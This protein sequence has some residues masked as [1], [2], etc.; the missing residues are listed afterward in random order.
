MI[1]CY[2]TYEKS[3]MLGYCETKEY[4]VVYQLIRIKLQ[5]T[6]VYLYVLVDATCIFD[7]FIRNENRQ[8]S[9]SVQ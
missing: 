2:L 9:F 7:G 3:S 4:D 6:H 1:I 8:F 5:R